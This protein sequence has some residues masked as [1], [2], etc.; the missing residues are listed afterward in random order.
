MVE[1]EEVEFDE[2]KSFSD[3]T[4]AIEFHKGAKTIEIIGTTVHGGTSPSFVEIIAVKS[5]VMGTS[6]MFNAASYDS[7]VPVVSYA[8]DLGDG[9]T[10]SG[11]SIK[12]IFEKQGVYMITLKVRDSSGNFSVDQTTITIIAKGGKY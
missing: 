4:L 10:S 1:G 8:W 7:D 12:H 2:T 11:E 6:I 3:R 9:T 5:G